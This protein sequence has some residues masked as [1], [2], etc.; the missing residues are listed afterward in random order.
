MDTLQQQLDRAHAQLKIPPG[1]LETTHHHA[2][3]ASTLLSCLR[4][5]GLGDDDIRDCMTVGDPRFVANWAV[6]LKRAP[7]A[8][9]RA[10]RGLSERPDPRRRR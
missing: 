4:Y 3:S 2:A 7:L 1:A 8:R 10:G 6:K 5:G 9:C